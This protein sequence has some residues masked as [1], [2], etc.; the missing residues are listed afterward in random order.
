MGVVIVKGE[1]QFWRVNLG[2]ALLHSKGELC[3]KRAYP[4]FFLADSWPTLLKRSW[5]RPWPHAVRSP[6]CEWH[7][8]IL[9]CH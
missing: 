2:R 6:L 7:F 1:G 3:K 5:R 9:F 4:I 8:D